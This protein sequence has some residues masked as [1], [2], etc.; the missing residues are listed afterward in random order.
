M[1]RIY[2]II[3]VIC[4]VGV[5]SAYS[6]VRV[7][8][9]NSSHSTTTMSP[10]QWLG[11]H[12]I[13][14]IR[15]EFQTDTD[16]KTYGDGR[17][18]LRT[19]GDRTATK[20]DY[21]TIFEQAE[22]VAEYVYENGTEVHTYSLRDYFR[23]VS[24]N[25]FDFNDII[26]TDIVTMSNPM[27]YYGDDADIKQSY[28][29][30]VADALSAASAYATRDYDFIVVLHSGAGEESDTTGSFTNDIVSGV[31]TADEYYEKTGSVL[32]FGAF[33]CNAVIILPETETRGNLNRGLLGP[34]AFTFGQA[35][36]M[37]LTIN[38]DGISS[39]LGLWDLMAYGLWNY[40]GFA[41]MHP[42]LYTKNLMGW[43]DITDITV[44]GLYQ[45]PAGAANVVADSW[46]GNKG[47]TVSINGN[48]FFLIEYRE[49]KGI[50]KYFENGYSVEELGTHSSGKKIIRETLVPMGVMMYHIRKDIF[51]QMPSTPL[52]GAIK[53][54]DIEEADGFNDLDK[55]WGQTGSLGDVYDC[56]SDHPLKKFRW[57]RFNDRTNPS[58]R[59]A[60]S[61]I[62]GISIHSIHCELATM[63]ASFVVENARADHYPVLKTKA[64]FASKDFYCSNNRTV[65]SFSDD[66]VQH[67]FDED[68]PI[69]YVVDNILF[70][71]KGVYLYGSL[72]TAS[73]TFPF[74]ITGVHREGNNWYVVGLH[75]VA[76]LD[77]DF[78]VIATAMEDNVERC[79][80]FNSEWFFLKN[81]E[82]F[83]G[84]YR[85]G[86]LLLLQG[87]RVYFSNEKSIYQRE[88]GQSNHI[89]TLKAL[90]RDFV[91]TDYDGDNSVELIVAYDDAIVFYTEK[92]EIER[93]VALSGVN[94]LVFAKE[95]N[96][97]F[98][99]TVGHVLS[100]Y[101][102]GSGIISGYTSYA[103]PTIDSLSTEAFAYHDISAFYRFPYFTAYRSGVVAEELSIPSVRTKDTK[104]YAYPNPATGTSITLRVEAMEGQQASISFYNARLQK[105]KQFSRVLHGGE[106]FLQ[107]D[108]SDLNTGTYMCVIDCEGKSQKI[109][110]S[111]LQ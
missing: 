20:M 47:Y 85:L 30:L 76:Q 78:T 3:A 33:A 102:W 37:P 53:G 50:E 96:E 49:R 69:L 25:L 44:N 110:I 43:A 14:V 92:G 100:R 95:G 68:E 36:G 51:E 41:P 17:F 39:G 57:M 54:I 103:A 58:A 2:S 48:E 12:S 32:Q 86:E 94:Q 101:N 62:S 74:E 72:P 84:D 16:T 65:V 31:L 46:T 109:K 18:V 23:E 21:F 99:L 5:V 56:F 1:K 97:Y 40:N 22:V 71:S 13:L 93:S 73:V 28:S 79:V 29:R 105:V 19:L 45:L 104:I 61:G 26:M 59:D 11:N 52:Y 70:T 4:I 24:N 55:P 42:T 87:T 89:V 38:M 106:N 6:I 77:A 15:V 88:N 67:V 81:N 64:L 111:V 10:K 98:L 60:S 9:T 82:W 66:Q 91:F 90:P 108:I 75:T 63:T 34:A 107:L 8:Y 83:Q 27:A 7:D 80:R 35:M